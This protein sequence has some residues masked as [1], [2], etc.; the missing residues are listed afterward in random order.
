MGKIPPQ[1]K[2]VFSGVIY[3]V[4]QWE[5]AMFDGSPAIFEMLRRPNTV[6]VI[7]MVGDQILLA[8]EEQPNKGPHWT[9]FGGRQEQDETP[10]QAAQRELLEESG[11]V[12]DNWEL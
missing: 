9:L 2:K 3:D 4:Y 5:Q 11:Y 7:P 12:S 1:A 8:F 6:C 10:I